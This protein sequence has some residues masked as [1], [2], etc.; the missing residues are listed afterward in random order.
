MGWIEQVHDTQIV[1]QSIAILWAI[2]LQRNQVV[3]HHNSPNIENTLEEARKLV[4]M[5]S[6][7]H[8]GNGACSTSENNQD[9]NTSNLCI[10]Q[11]VL[12]IGSAI[13]S[14]HFIIDG[15][16]KS[17]TDNA[18]IVWICLDNQKQ[19]IK[20]QAVVKTSLSHAL[21][22]E[23]HACLDA[24]RWAVQQEMKHINVYTDCQVLVQMLQQQRYQEHWHIFTL[25]QDILA[26]VKCLN[27]VCL[28]K[29]D[30]SVIQPAHNTAKNVTTTTT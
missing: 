3:F 14:W 13:N 16:W 21:L 29:V 10:L 19:L 6:C 26:Y 22:A 9:T 25:V 1:I 30:R 5:F 23:A 2:W 28:R 12:D 20:R 7:L 24:I 15:S 8:I 11:N 27:Y 18:R 17:P 4:D